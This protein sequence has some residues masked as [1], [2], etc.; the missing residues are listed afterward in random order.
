MIKSILRNKAI[1]LTL[2]K[3]VQ[4][5]V[6]KPA[7]GM[8]FTMPMFEYVYHGVTGNHQDDKIFLGLAPK[9]DF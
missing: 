7:G 8:P 5:C 4:K 6:G 1:P 3:K 9:I 2:R